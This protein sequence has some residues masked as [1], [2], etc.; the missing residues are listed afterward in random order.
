MFHAQ[1]QGTTGIQLADVR[2]EEIFFPVGPG[3][4]EGTFVLLHFRAGQKRSGLLEVLHSGWLGKPNGA[5][6]PGDR[7]ISH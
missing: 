3:R 6:L 5:W 2:E 1:T 7:L 4:T